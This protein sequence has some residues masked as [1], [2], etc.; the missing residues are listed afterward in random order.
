MPRVIAVWVSSEIRVNKAS[1]RSIDQLSE[2]A[3]VDEIWNRA[4]SETE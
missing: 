2:K 3:T 4:D 1:A